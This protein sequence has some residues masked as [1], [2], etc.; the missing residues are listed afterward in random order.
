MKKLI[1]LG[2]LFLYSSIHAQVE[3]YQLCITN[4]SDQIYAIFC[5]DLLDSLITKDENLKET[6]SDF[7]YHSKRL[8]K[9]LSIPVKIYGS[10][11]VFF[12]KKKI[13]INSKSPFTYLFVRKGAKYPKILKGVDSWASLKDQAGK[14]FASSD[15]KNL[16]RYN[17]LK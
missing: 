14:Y 5:K 1:F 6:Y 7:I 12:E 3:E 2:F 8:K 10:S 13:D 17:S 15:S 16:K 11:I 9:E 4:H